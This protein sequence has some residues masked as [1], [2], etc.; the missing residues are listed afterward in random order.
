MTL[1]EEIEQSIAGGKGNATLIPWHSEPDLFG[2]F[3]ETPQASIEAAKKELF[4]CGWDWS[5]SRNQMERGGW[6]VWF[7][8]QGML[9]APIAQWSLIAADLSAPARVNQ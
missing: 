3:A 1:S 5:H 2:G 6:K 9:S 8:S 7:R 4:H